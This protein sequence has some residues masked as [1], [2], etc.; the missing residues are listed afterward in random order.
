MKLVGSYRKEYSVVA[1]LIIIIIIPWLGRAY[2]KKAEAGEERERG[3]SN[4]TAQ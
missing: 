1:I 3:S 4:G 2:E